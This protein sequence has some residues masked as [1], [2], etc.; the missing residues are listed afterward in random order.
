MTESH[1]ILFRMMAKAT[2]RYQE[3]QTQAFMFMSIFPSTN[4]YRLQRQEQGK[5]KGNQQL[6]GLSLSSFPRDNHFSK[7]Y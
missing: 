2:W 6:L 1:P 5:I 4:N 7:P 3:L